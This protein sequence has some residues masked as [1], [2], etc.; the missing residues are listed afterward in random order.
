MANETWVPKTELGRKVASGEITSIDDIIASGKP[1]LESEIVDKLL[2]DMQ[3]EVFEMRYT[4]RMSASGRKQLTRVAVVLGNKRGYLAYAIGKAPLA[5]DAIAAG[6]KEAKKHVI[7]LRLG[8]GSWECGCAQEHSV[9]Q[10][11]VGKSGSTMLIIKP[12]PR[13]AG[14][15]ANASTKKILELAGVRD[16]WTF[17]KGRTRNIL[18]TVQ[19][20]VNALM[21]LNAIKVGAKSEEVEEE[22]AETASEAGAAA[23]AAA[24]YK[25]PEPVEAQP[26][27]SEAKETVGKEAGTEGAENP[28]E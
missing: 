23:E 6:V 15:A 18:N 9:P 2:P 7:K 22:P 17:A 14:I 24:D 19:A 27:E 3:E 11:V 5:R 26:A 1:V 16:V 21:K 10:S 8:C 12:A 28:K 13:G 20:T 25:Q 4:Q